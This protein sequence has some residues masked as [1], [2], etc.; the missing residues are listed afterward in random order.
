MP[1]RITRVVLEAEIVQFETA[2]RRAGDATKQ[3]S[4][5][6]KKLAD[7]HRAM[8]QLGTGM[9]AAGVAVAAGVGLAVAKFAEF[10]QAMSNVEATG[11]DARENLDALRQAA[12][13][14][15]AS[16]VFS[17]T[18]AANAIE[19][20]AK[21]GLSAKDILGGGLK[22]SLDLAAAG[23]LGVAEAAAI[24]STTLKQF[25]LDGEDA[26]HV[27]D[28]L[29]AG[30]GK[31]MG[32]VTDMGAALNQAGLV[33]S[34]FGLSVDETVGTLSAF[35]SAGML[36]SDAGTS[37]RTMLLRLANPTNEVASLMESL[38]I[39]A[40][41]TAGNFVGL[42][43][44]AGELELGLK[45]MTQAQKDQT[46]AMIF[47]QDAIR[48]AN[49]L[50]REGSDGIADWT[51]KVNDQGYAAETAETRLENLIGDWEAF[52]GALDTAFITM[53]E[54]V[55]GPLRALVQGLTGLVDGF[56][57][58]P[59]GAKQ[60][61]LWAGLLAAGIGILGG[62][63][64]IA[65]PKIAAFQLAM[66]SLGIS[67]ASA[68]A[69]L[70][71]FASFMVG[72]WG[73]AMVAATLAVVA[74]QGAT[75]K[76]SASTEEFQNV[77]QNATSADEIF[78]TS[79]NAVPFLSQLDQ[80][81]GSAE[82]FKTALDQL[83]N[84]PFLAGVGGTA[85]LRSSL[86]D[87]GDELST[88][89]ETDAPAAARAFN[90]IANEME[91]SKAEQEDLLNAMGPY[92]DALVRQA[93]AQ[94]IDVTNKSG[95]IDATKLLNLVTEE[96]VDSST[97]AA[98]AY[99]AE[100][101]EVTALR[102]ELV[103]LIETMNEAN[104]VGQDAVTQNADY[105]QTLA[106]V[107]E[108]IAAITAGTEGYAAGLDLST[109]AGRDNTGMLVQLAADSQ[110]AAEAQFALDGS[111]QGYTDRM[112]V[113][114]QA[115]IDSALAMG[116][117]QDEA[118]ALAD[119]IYAIPSEK[120]I[121]ILAE[122]QAAQ[123]AIDRLIINNNG[124]RITISADVDYQAA[125]GITV[126][127]NASGGLY[128]GGVK[129]FAAGEFLPGIY[130]ATP[131]G[132]HRF[133]EAGYDEMYGTADP[134]YKERTRGIWTTFGDRMGFTQ[135]EQQPLSLDGVSISG[136]LDLG[137]GLTGFVEGRINSYDAKANRATRGGVRQDRL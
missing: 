105:Q 126:T 38:G 20:L 43:G 82:S 11:D 49:I 130:P 58:L 94:Q 47:G 9:L 40:Y 73:V 7:T 131:G 123:N 22:G 90:L 8:T 114:R 68:R 14:A 23:G 29:A 71:R 106:D 79:D 110:A 37:M 70:V 89:A 96:S 93:N 5:E 69:G 48:G 92:R 125:G 13:D 119:K 121:Q 51:D 33:A 111:T 16:T 103:S 104:G 61:V 120:E 101:D 85:D 117:T 42:S 88:L 18:E 25:R 113:G 99:T 4:D 27:A 15:G 3:V 98:E 44:L 19:E 81:T 76:L 112:A 41:D 80:A 102:D 31:A 97:S 34:Q 12:L 60:A 136:T 129:E 83:T 77:L 84:N 124:R 135:G 1:E 64:L 74:L 67:G 57:D 137:N 132:I 50:L 55:D 45:D 2:M 53:G 134:K 108:H 56:N 115:L 17:A 59:D 107:S 30:A 52:T 26:S 100:A 62:A 21:A 63:A 10:D 116:A 95:Q 87:I 75:D 118:V 32:D 24:A 39:N 28:L 6:G 35:A 46:L 72:P 54:G 65:V 91:L 109:Q 86:K 128:S 122:T 66:V 133:A 36:G 127:P 78:E